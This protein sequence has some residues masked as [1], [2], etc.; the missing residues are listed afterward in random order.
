[1]NLRHIEVFYAI[2]QSGSVTAAAHLL[3]VTQPSVSNVL[4]HAEQQLGLKLFERIGGRLQPTPEAYDLFPD[5]QEIF[6]RI[7]T[8]NRMVEE[9]QGGRTGRLAVA[10]A[11]TLVN[12]Y[13]PKAISK[14]KTFGSQVTIQS[15]PTTL[16]T[17]RV[18]RREVDIGFVYGPVLDPGVLMEALSESKLVCAVHRQSPLARHKILE[19]KHL[20]TTTVISTGPTTRIGAGIREA[21]ETGGFPVPRVAVEVN[22]SLAACLMAAEGV[23]VGLVDLATVNQ[24]ALPGVVLRPFRPQVALQLCLIFPKDRP[25]SRATMRFAQALRELVAGA[26]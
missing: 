21:C 12:A 8:L 13:I 7:G 6:G 19:P 26:D 14:L 17:E 3:N 15:L 20:E 25:Q 23:G 1:M 5:V 18:A 2:M 9:M 10:A 24:Y 4:R 16:V 11:P 22:S